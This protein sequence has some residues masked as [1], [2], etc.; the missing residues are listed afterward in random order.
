[1]KRLKATVGRAADMEGLGIGI[2]KEN[3]FIAGE[4]LA[5]AFICLFV[6]SKGWGLTHNGTKSFCSPGTSAQN[7]GI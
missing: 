3:A 1:M 6:L 5:N 2:S 4:G 7:A